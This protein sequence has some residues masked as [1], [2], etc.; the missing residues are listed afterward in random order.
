METY[1]TKEYL[2]DFEEEITQLYKDGQIP[3]ATHLRSGCEDQ[4]IE[5]FKNIRPQDYVFGYWDSHLLALCK[6][7]P[8]EVVKQAIMDGHSIAMCLPKY[9][10]YCS[11]I[12]GSMMSVAVGV[13]LAIKRKGL[14]EHVYLYCGDMASCGAAFFEA[15]QYA[16]NWDLPI[17]FIVG[18]NGVSVLTN[19][20]EVWG[21]NRG[22]HV[23]VYGTFLWFQH[24]HTSIDHTKIKYFKYINGYS[25]SG[26]SKKVAF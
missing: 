8:K 15:I 17:T 6:G 1:I 16:S 2:V 20:R 14:N 18:D 22:K 5:V 9:R 23:G 7:I 21:I 19:T 3:Y 10:F 24:N 25:H 11:G 12:L 26:I 4:L 13:A